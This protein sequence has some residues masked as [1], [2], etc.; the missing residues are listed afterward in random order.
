[1]GRLQNISI[2]KF[3]AESET[4]LSLSEKVKSKKVISN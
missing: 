1:M 2:I 4:F 3:P